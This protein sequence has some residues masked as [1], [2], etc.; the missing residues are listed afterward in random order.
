M[1]ETMRGESGG[2]REGDRDCP[3]IDPHLFLARTISHS[4][5]GTGYGCQLPVASY[6]LS[7]PLSLYLC[8][9]PCAIVS[10]QLS[11]LLGYLQWKMFVDCF[12]DKKSMLRAQCAVLLFVIV[13]LL[14]GRYLT[15][16]T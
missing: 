1:W 12:C 16:F 4:N 2:E 8:G 6:Q 10:W 11:V 3:F 14:F 13:T 5:T 9:T 15:N 7:V